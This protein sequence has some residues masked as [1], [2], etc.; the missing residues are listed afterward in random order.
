[1]RVVHGAQASWDSNIA[2]ATL[3][4]TIALAVW[5]QCNK[6]IAITRDDTKKVDVL[7][8]S[9]LQGLQTLEYPQ[10]TLGVHRALIFS[11]DSRVLTY[12]SHDGCYNVLL[13]SWDLQTGGT[14][15]T[16][17]QREPIINTTENPSIAYSMNGKI[18]GVFYWCR[19]AIVIHVYNV[20]SG[21]HMHSY[22][23][24][25][26][27]ANGHSLSNYGTVSSDVWTHGE[28]FRFA[29]I[30]LTTIAIW[31]VGFTPRATT[32][33]EVETIAVSREVGAAVLCYGD[34]GS[35]RK[36]V[37]FLLASCRLA[38]AYAD[39]VL[40]W[41]ARSSRSLLHSK[42]RDSKYQEMMSFSSDG[43][44]FACPTTGLEIHLW[45][46]S[47]TGYTLHGTLTPGT[48]NSIPLLSPNGKSVV[49]FGGATIRLWHTKSFVTTSSGIPAGGPQHT[50]NFALDFSPDGTFAA[51]VRKGE[52]V[53]TVLD[54][55]SGVPQLTINASMEVYGLRVTGNA[56]VVIGD[57]RIIT[58]NL[59]AGGCVPNPSVN[60]GDC[61][62]TI[63]FSRPKGGYVV[64]A[65]IS[66]DLQHVA[67]TR[68]FFSGFLRLDFYSGSI[69]KY[70][71]VVT[72]DEEAT[73]FSSDGCSLWYT[74]VGG[75]KRSWTITGGLLC[76]A[77]LV[78]LEHP[79]EGY[80]WGSSHG[81]R[82]TNDGW[83]FGPDG[84]RLLM[85][86][87]HW[88]SDPTQRVWNGQFLALLHGALPGPVILELDL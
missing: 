44:F 22:V 82:A 78:D 29:T 32:L 46:E 8:S 87:P 50:A 35:L 47:L 77:S 6:F 4:S 48:N 41:D 55:Q 58:W 40:V 70:L 66:P 75:I 19:D 60:I 36:R 65:S 10:D 64:A 69:G 27:F 30:G 1:M 43:R 80:P 13:I 51:V 3:P 85:L 52:N 71:G 62:Q 73:W 49:A 12:S 56:V 76:E 33:T 83:V 15:S 45:K 68:K 54:L 28:S 34:D 23:L 63:S 37:R 38:F 9:T 57:S 11:P 5:S 18:V 17:K 14:V 20:I 24:Y 42:R 7:D 25:S 81:Y 26:P 31:E 74:L 21:V 67:L 16:I 88:R 86:P 61:A 79:P 59:P 84:K 53:V 2:A 72:A 39:K